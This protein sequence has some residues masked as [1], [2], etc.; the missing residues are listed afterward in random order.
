MSEAGRGSCGAA[1]RGEPWRGREARTGLAGGHG[2][3]E[4][5]LLRAKQRR[6]KLS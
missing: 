5:P 2:S 1:G 4:E 3:R 6:E